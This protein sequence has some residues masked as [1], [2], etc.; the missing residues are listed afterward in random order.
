MEILIDGGAKL[1]I[2]QVDGYPVLAGSIQQGCLDAAQ[3][4]LKKGANPNVTFDSFDKTPLMLACQEGNTEAIK[5]LV[6]AGALA[7]QM[8]GRGR[9]AFDYA[10]QK[11]NEDVIQCLKEAVIEI[12]GQTSQKTQKFGKMTLKRTGFHA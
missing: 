5:M 10:E 9:T 2:A 8:D 4:L 12:A 1:D 6:K 11:G 3:V 7:T